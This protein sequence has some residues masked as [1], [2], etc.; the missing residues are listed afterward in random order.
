MKGDQPQR[1]DRRRFLQV[2]ALIAA[3]AAAAACEQR[4]SQRDVAAGAGGNSAGGNAAPAAGNQPPGNNAGQA[5]AK[6]SI[7]GPGDPM[8]QGGAGMK[9]GTLLTGG[10]LVNTTSGEKNYLYS[11]LNLDRFLDLRARGE[12]AF[13]DWMKASARIIPELGFL[14][15]GLAPNPRRPERV[16]VFEKKG[17]GAAELDLKTNSIITRISPLKGHEFYGHGAY[18]PDG[19]VIYA[20]EY[21]E[22]TYEGKITLRDAA[23]FKITGEFPTYGE[24]PHDCQF[25][26]GGRVVAVTNGGGDEASG[27]A[28]NVTYMEVSSGK[29]LEKIVFDNPKINSG[30]LLV[31]RDGSL[32]VVHAMRQGLDTRSALGAL[33]LRP[34]GGTFLTMTEPANITQQMAGE[35]LS[36][37]YHE[38]TDVVAATNPF[39]SIITFWSMRQQRNLGAIK[40]KQPRGV[41]L[42]MDQRFFVV[43]FDKDEPKFML[44]PTDTR[45]VPEGAERLVY[46][47]PCEGSH[48][49]IYD[50]A[51]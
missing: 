28:P 29:L 9:Y 6:A 41:G 5:N 4:A 47:L 1:S 42:T 37:C 27:Q 26:D 13:A 22:G 23:D 32:C 21:V 46:P 19:R 45:Q 20:T 39:G 33:S 44:V 10:S 48:A 7:A 11:Q 43:T 35:T 40:V 15:H 25:I 34:S 17:D 2:G 16:L 31:T 50:Y 18:S 51:V 3:S 12:G 8:P 24:W 30:H 14:A 38:G 49:Y 36:I